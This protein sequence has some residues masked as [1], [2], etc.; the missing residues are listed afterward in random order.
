MTVRI[1]HAIVEALMVDVI[2]PVRDGVLNPDWVRDRAAN[3]AVAI[4][5]LINEEPPRSPVDFSDPRIS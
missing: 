4:E 1:Q 5:A 2:P 3:L